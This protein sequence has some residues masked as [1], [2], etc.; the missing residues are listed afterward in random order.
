MRILPKSFHRKAN[1]PMNKIRKSSQPPSQRIPLVI[2]GDQ[3]GSVTVLFV[4]FA[5]F[6]VGAISY[7]LYA[8]Q[9]VE[10]KIVLQNASDSSSIAVANHSGQGLNMISANNLAIGASI[11][12]AGAV[13]ILSAYISAGWVFTADGTK[14]GKEFLKLAIEQ[15][16]GENIEIQNVFQDK[17]WNKFAIIPS[18]YMKIASGLTK[19]NDFLNGYWMVPAGISGM[20]M[21]RVNLPG[22][23]SIPF[24]KSDKLLKPVVMNYGGIGKTTPRSTV[25]HAIKASAAGVNLL[26]DRSSKASAMEVRDD[27]A[28][29][30]FGP[31]KSMNNKDLNSATSTL[32]KLTS[33]AN[34]LMPIKV[35]FVDCGYGLKMSIFALLDT[36][37]DSA[38]NS[39]AAALLIIANSKV[40]FVDAALFAAKDGIPAP[41][42][43]IKTI[44]NRFT[45]KKIEV[46]APPSLKRLDWMR[47][48]HLVKKALTAYALAKSLENPSKYARA[49][50]RYEAVEKMHSEKKGYDCNQAD[51]VIDES[52]QVVVGDVRECIEVAK[53]IPECAMKEYI[54]GSVDTFRIGLV[55]DIQG[56]GND[57][58]KSIRQFAT[59]GCMPYDKFADEKDGA[60]K[61][62]EYRIHGISIAD[63]GKQAEAYGKD[64]GD[65]RKTTLAFLFPVNEK[66]F[67]DANTF[68]TLSANALRTT[69]EVSASSCPKGYTVEDA[70]KVKRCDH[71]PLVA[72]ST[73]MQNDKAVFSSPDVK[74][75]YE[76]DHAALTSGMNKM[77]KAGEVAGDA[78]AGALSN[79]WSRVQWTTSGSKVA[80]KVGES[81]PG[82]I[83]N[84]L[85]WPAWQSHL[86]SI[87]G[88]SLKSML[89]T[90]TG[91]SDSS[92]VSALKAE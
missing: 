48:E 88:E 6:L 35:G 17:I 55:P 23:L 2:L 51:D 21:H 9:Q 27:F 5:M 87:D 78:A 42:R 90:V 43:V 73:D 4:F 59:V 71:I 64:G 34:K 63:W 33:T 11:H 65:N 77:V 81:V 54:V 1:S 10:K 61:D 72:F 60:S 84:Q 26:N 58:A 82:S 19:Y 91:G 3:K 52:V 92:K 53:I 32:L 28:Q 74:K 70:E 24:Q 46:R 36:A 20:E 13:P 69:A 45:G 44:R 75:R 15:F 30:L 89:G 7:A 50:L 85:F 25:C 83:R 37:M 67:N 14:A 68:F 76:R 8:G 49:L 40:S 38:G 80:F 86:Y 47:S 62:E 29:W 18:F 22:S 66:E 39:P 56:I 41:P 79:V 16:T 31:L 12:V 57:I